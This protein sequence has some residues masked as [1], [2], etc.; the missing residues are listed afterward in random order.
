MNSH[1]YGG[2]LRR[3][4]SLLSHAILCCIV[5]A[6]IVCGAETTTSNSPPRWPS[7]AEILKKWENSSLDTVNQAAE[8]GDLTAQHYLGY[9]NVEGFHVA[10]NPAAGIAWYQRAL[11]SGY[12]P[13]ANNLGLVYQRGLAGTNDMAKAVYYYRYAADRGLAQ[14]QA[15]LGVLYCDGDGVERNFTEAMKWFRRAA[16]QGH[17]TAMVEI[18]RR[19]RLGQGVPK[20]TSE[21]V[22]WFKMAA[23]KN[24]PLGLVNL[25][26]MY[27]YE[28]AT[29]INQETAFKF[30]Q[31]AAELGQ[32]DAMY[33]IYLLY[34]NQTGVVTNQAEAMKWLGKAAEGDNCMAQCLLGY[35]YEYPEWEVSGNKRRLPP[36]NMPEAVR[37]YRSS[38]DRSWADG[39]Y[40]LGLCYIA[41][42]GVE[43]D[44]EH[45]LELIRQAAG[46]NHTYALFELAGLYARGIGEPRNDE[47][48]P[49][50]LLRRVVK[51]DPRENYHKIKEAYDSLIFRYEYGIGTERDIIAAVQ[52]YCRAAAAG[53]E[54]Y[55]IED[56]IE[57]GPQKFRP[58]GSYT[59]DSERRLIAI[60]RPDPGGRSDRFLS[61]LSRYLKAASSNNHD[62]LMEIGDMYLAGQDAPR[63]TVK[64]W[65]WFSLAAQNGVS[66][67]RSKISQAET[68]MTESEL[69]EAKQLLPGLVQEL[70]TI[71]AAL[72]GATR[73]PNRN[74]SGEHP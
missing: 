38:A 31:R 65:L 27:G 14:A 18:G 28:A 1:A 39:Q 11:E 8:K 73:D 51:C 34:Q 74:L 70:N 17:A 7:L 48:R 16:D 26:W 4:F 13:S 72:R 56:K 46:Q 63:N 64:A 60:S 20:N 2:L 37:W 49:I 29:P 62:G 10:K 36:P 50:A 43:Q 68:R 35:F 57:V 19:Y 21:A 9:C 44:E 67:A 22:R 32:T 52:W 71:A 40:H 5:A 55:T 30:Y 33:E 45:G 23:D 54:G 6:A 12:I 42:K 66:A 61:A 47:D 53:M 59:G 24:D 15:N 58:I 41:G 25:G 3:R 69:K